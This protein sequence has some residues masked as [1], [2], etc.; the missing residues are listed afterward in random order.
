MQ[1]DMTEANIGRCPSCNAAVYGG[2]DACR[3]FFES[4]LGQEYTA[5]RFAK[6]HRMMVD[7]YA[8]QHPAEYMKSGKSF[9]A[10]LTG[11]LAV[12]EHDDAE[13]VNRMVQTWLSS[14]PA[15]ERPADP[16]PPYGSLTVLDCFEEND[17]DK[18]RQVVR[19]WLESAWQAW[20]DYHELA[21]HLI[22]RAGVR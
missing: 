15:I 20:A 6:V 10:H 8:L 17:P 1:G 16:T 14:N 11:A 3:E 4:L 18:Y 13:T 5:Y 2:I 21:H 12:I 19:Q 22:A 7:A 9:A